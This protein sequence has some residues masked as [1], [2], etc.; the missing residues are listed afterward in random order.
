MSGVSRLICII[1]STPVC[2]VT[3]QLQDHA[4]PFEEHTLHPRHD[5]T[6]SGRNAHAADR[7]PAEKERPSTG[8]SRCNQTHSTILRADAVALL[9]SVR[10]STA[11]GL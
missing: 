7:K 11:T 1:F 9:E 8:S 5:A 3:S 10:T 2:V 4:R 6:A